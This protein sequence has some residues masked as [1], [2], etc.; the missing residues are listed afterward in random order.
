MHRLIAITKGHAKRD[1]F[2]RSMLNRFVSIFWC[3]V[4]KKKLTIKHYDT[5]SCIFAEEGMKEPVP[6]VVNVKS[7][8][9]FAFTK[10]FSIDDEEMLDTLVNESAELALL[11]CRAC[12]RVFM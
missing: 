4:T 6:L 8:S 5:I 3:K 7:F 2:L 10:I 9:I 1:K 11:T 12:Q